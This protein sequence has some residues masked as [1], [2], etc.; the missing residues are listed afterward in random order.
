MT[1]PAGY[2]AFTALY[3]RLEFRDVEFRSQGLRLLTNDTLDLLTS[4]SA[5]PLSQA[6]MLNSPT[7]NLP[8]N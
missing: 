4:L 3:E 8:C 1:D 2:H 7:F 5:H 6:R